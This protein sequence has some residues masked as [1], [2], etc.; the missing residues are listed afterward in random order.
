M[1]SNIFATG[2]NAFNDAWDSTQGMFDHAAR[3][4]AGRALAGGD[5]S[6]AMTALGD[7][8]QIDAV[9]VLQGDQRREEA[10]AYDRERDTIEDQRTAA[11]TLWEA[12]DLLSKMPI[13][14]G[15]RPEEVRWQVFSTHPLFQALIPD[16]MRSQI[17][18]EH[19]SNEGLAMF[20]EKVKSQMVQLGGGGVGEYTPGPNGGPGTLK[21]LREPDPKLVAAREGTTLIDSVTREPIYTK[22]KTYAPPR[23]GG[24]GRSG[25]KPKSYSPDEVNW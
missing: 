10:D 11:K 6:G 4:K 12:S 20:M 25:G 15:K 8:G 9:R 2:V 21:V 22:P 17:K 16:E 14:E 23:A 13:P 3:R 19:L 18:P 7:S 1:A 24:A 5:R